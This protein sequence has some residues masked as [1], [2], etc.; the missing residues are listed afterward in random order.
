MPAHMSVW[1]CLQT[2]SSSSSRH[3]L[4]AVPRA[5]PAGSHST[6]ESRLSTFALTPFRPPKNDTFHE[7]KA[8]FPSDSSP[9]RL[10]S[11]V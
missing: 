11:E 7:G 6:M 3:G 2:S 5:V 1:E 4:C 8:D 10:P 9:P